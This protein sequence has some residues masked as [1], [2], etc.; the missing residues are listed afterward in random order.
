CGSALAMRVGH[1]RVV[2][3]PGAPLQATV[4][5]QEV[6]PEEISSLKVSIADEAAW[7]RAG[8]KPPVPLA[9]MVVRVEDGMDPTRKN[10]RVRS[11]QAPA[12]GAGDLLL[13]INS[14]SGQR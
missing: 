12:G 8:V 5:L 2:S 6:T 9:S 11:T 14:S 7:Q 10:L 4:G 1:S 3:V 13:D